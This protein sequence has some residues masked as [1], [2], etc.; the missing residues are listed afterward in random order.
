[1]LV[2]PGCATDASAPL[3]PA[4]LESVAVDEASGLATSPTDGNFLW[5]INDSGGTPDL[6]LAG[7]D[8]SD[9]GKVRLEGV[10]NRDW[11]DLA[12]FTLD[13]KAYLLVA[14]TGDNQA[15]HETS[16]FYVI[17]EPSLPA[18]GKRLEGVVKPAWRIDFRYEGGPRD[19]EAVAVDAAAGKIVFLSKRTKPPELYELPLRAPGASG[20]VQTASPLGRLEVKPPGG[21]LIPFADQPTGLSLAPDRSSAAV[22]TYFGV[23]LFPRQPEESWA[24]AF[25]RKPVLLGAHHLGQAESVAFSKD[26]RWLRV[27]AEG[28]HAPIRSFPLPEPAA[29]REGP[30]KSE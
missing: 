19:C 3:P 17:R 8:G 29:V 30:V 24:E 13:G 7:T 6:H 14:E 15:A 9:R 23:F 16:T 12:A 1:M 26:G 4:R 21:T 2:L 18:P 22:V 28:L 11:E 20:S 5:L 25:G 27:V 10:P